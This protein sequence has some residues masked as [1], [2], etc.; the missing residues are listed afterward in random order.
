MGNLQT[1]STIH[2]LIIYEYRIHQTL[3]SIRD[4][5]VPSNRQ[6]EE[7]WNFVL[8][9]RKHIRNARL[10]TDIFEVILLYCTKLYSPNWIQKLVSVIY[11]DMIVTQSF[12][13]NSFQLLNIYARL[14]FIC[15]LH[16]IRNYN[17]NVLFL[18]GCFQK[19]KIPNH[20]ILY[21]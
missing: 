10:S 20:I 2:I 3:Q 9:T 5:D 16:S 15:H 7:Y 6:K 18:F 11:T 4:P 13:K 17:K 14:T 19:S 21:W 1:K 8:I 12:I